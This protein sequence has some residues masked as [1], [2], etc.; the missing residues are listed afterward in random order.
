MIKLGLF[1]VKSILEMYRQKCFIFVE[2]VSKKYLEDT[3]KAYF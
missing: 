2:T 3:R 1:W